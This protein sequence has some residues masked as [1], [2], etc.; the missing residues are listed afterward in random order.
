LKTT[1]CSEC[2]LNALAID[3]S[4]GYAKLYPGE[5]ADMADA[6]YTFLSLFF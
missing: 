2:T 6:K 4:P 1:L 3:E 5:Y